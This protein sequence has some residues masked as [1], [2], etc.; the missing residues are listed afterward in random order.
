MNK[1]EKQPI[2]TLLLQRQQP[3][4]D[5]LPQTGNYRLAIGCTG[6]KKQTTPPALV[7]N[8]GVEFNSPHQT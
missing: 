6:K 7:G 3:D 5:K 1:S 2:A 8:D 4:L